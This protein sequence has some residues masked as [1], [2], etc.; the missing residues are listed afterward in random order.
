MFDEDQK[1]KTTY[2]RNLL[3]EQNRSTD[4]LKYNEDI[5]SK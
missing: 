5:D 2:T 4:L 1:M 3:T